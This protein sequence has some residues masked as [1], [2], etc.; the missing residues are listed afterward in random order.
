MIHQKIP[1]NCPAIDSANRISD[2][3]TAAQ[4]KKLPRRTFEMLQLQ[5]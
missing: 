2:V 5:G 1:A 3:L 4:P